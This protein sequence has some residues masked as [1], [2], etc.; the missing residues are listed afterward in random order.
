MTFTKRDILYKENVSF[1]TFYKE[2]LLLAMK[3]LTIDVDLVNE[4]ERYSTIA[5]ALSEKEG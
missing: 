2:E 3:Q 1:H 4:K 5:I